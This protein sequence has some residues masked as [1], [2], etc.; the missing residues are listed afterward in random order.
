MTRRAGSSGCKGVEQELLHPGTHDI[1]LYLTVSFTC[2]RPMDQP[3]LGSI[4]P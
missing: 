1:R 3:N 4:N 2:R